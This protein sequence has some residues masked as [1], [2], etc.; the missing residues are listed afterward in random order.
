MTYLCTWHY[1]IICTVL[2]PFFY[3]S[4][5]FSS[6][7]FWEIFVQYFY[8]Q[9]RVIENLFHVGQ[10]EKK[11]SWFN[12]NWV[13]HES[14]T[15]SN[16]MCPIDNQGQFNLY[17]FS[18]SVHYLTRAGQ[19]TR[20]HCHA[21]LHTDCSV[22]KHC[23]KLQ[24]NVTKWKEISGIVDAYLPLTWGFIWCSVSMR[25][26]QML[27]SRQK[28]FHIILFHIVRSSKSSFKHSRVRYS[29]RRS[30]SILKE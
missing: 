8:D 22:V 11:Y 21:S 6:N 12:F 28:L 4:L 27:Q 13:K 7:E 9:L 14:L 20:T 24:G 5:H 23:W 18:S 19:G 16:L 3:Y 30:P 15:S 2:K 17:Q 26:E 10:G 1:M 29:K 25:K